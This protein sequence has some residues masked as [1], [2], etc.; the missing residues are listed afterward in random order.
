MLRRQ[1]PGHCSHNRPGKCTAVGLTARK[2]RRAARSRRSKPGRSIGLRSPATPLIARRAA[3][4]FLPGAVGS[5]SADVP[6]SSSCSNSFVGAEHSQP[7]AQRRAQQPPFFREFLFLV[8]LPPVRDLFVCARHLF[9]GAMRSR[10]SERCVATY[11][12]D[13]INQP[14][15]AHPSATHPTVWR[16]RTNVWRKQTNPARGAKQ[17]RSGSADH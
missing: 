14:L 15:L 11:K 1:G 8:A 13:V 7:L 2:R 6:K 10:V 9:V 5:T 3:R 17:L 16:Q 4:E 12:L